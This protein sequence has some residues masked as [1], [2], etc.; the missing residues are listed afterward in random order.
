MSGKVLSYGNEV[1]VFENE[2]SIEEI[3]SYNVEF[4]PNPAHNNVRF[5][6]DY[7]DG[8]LSVLILNANGQEVKK[9]TFSGSKTVDVSDLTSG[10]YFVKILGNTMTTKKLVIR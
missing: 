10:V 5:S 1:E 4:F 2:T 6:S 7:E 9:F 8:K 3:P